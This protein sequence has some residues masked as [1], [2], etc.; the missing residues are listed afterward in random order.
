MRIGTRANV[1][2]TPGDDLL[3]GL[4][5]VLHSQ[6]ERQLSDWI[7]YGKVTTATRA[8][9]VARPDAADAALVAPGTGESSQS[10]APWSLCILWRCREPSGIATGPSG[11]GALLAQNVEQSELGRRD[12]VGAIPADQRTVPAATTKAV[13]P[14]QGTASYRHTVKQLLKSVV[15]QIRTLRSVGAGGGQLPP[16]TR[17]VPGDWYPYRDRQSRTMR[18]QI[19]GHWPTFR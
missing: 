10:N 11:R 9:A 8:D 2:E 3:L 12:P 5:P 15:R 13:S 1:A 6:S 17:W 7:A 16:A 14:L 4:Y 19:G 18:I